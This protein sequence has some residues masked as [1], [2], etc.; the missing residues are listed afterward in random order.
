MRTQAEG[1][2]AAGDC[3]ESIHRSL[4]PAGRL[5]AL[6]THANKQGGSRASTSAGGYATFPGVIA[7]PSP[8]SCDL[9]G[10]AATG[11]SEREAEQ[12]G[13]RFRHRGGRLDDDAPATSP[14]PPRSGSS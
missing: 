14:A 12:A 13:H 7:R 9:E 8:S 1:V 3:V 4:G 6:G 10:S 5:V 11:L 2:W